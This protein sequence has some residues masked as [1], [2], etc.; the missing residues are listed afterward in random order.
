MPETIAIDVCIATFK[1]PFALRELLE[2]LRN[3]DLTGISMRLIVVDNDRQ[4]SARAIVDDFRTGSGL[5][6]VYDVEQQQNISLA[7][8][9]ALRH[10]QADHFA[11]VDDDETVCDAW[12]HRLVDG[13]HRYQADIV[14]GPVISILPADAPAWVQ[15]NFKRARH[16]SGAKLQTGGAGN[17]LLK[18]TVLAGTQPYFNPSFGLTGGEDTDFFYRMYLAGRRLIWCDDAWATEP[19]APERLTVA[20]LRRRAFRSG[21]NFMKIFVRRFPFYK[22]PIWFALKS[23]QI[24]GALL[25]LPLVRLTSYP[26]Y[27]ALTARLAAASGQ[28]SYCFFGKDCE[29]YRT[30]SIH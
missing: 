24:T 7:R 3:Q 23:A 13:L 6:V 14:F 15:L 16:D 21:Q 22:K 2:S 28:L 27:V 26:R 29:E 10:V 12:L 25:V 30:H 11:F 9:R 20:W 19:V 5:Q 18:R 17:V 8:N 4:Q 1:R